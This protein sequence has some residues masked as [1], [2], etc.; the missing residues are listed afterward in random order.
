[1]AYTA[2]SVVYGEQPTAA[3]WNQLGQND[4]GFRDGTNIDDDTILERH[5]ADGEVTFAK[6]DGIWWEELGRTTLGSG[7]DT[8]SVASFTARKYLRIL[9]HTF[10]SN[11]RGALRFNNDSGNNYAYRV[12]DS[13]GADSTGT[14]FNYFVVGDAGSNST[15]AFST[16]D[17]INVASIEKI[18]VGQTVAKTAAGAGTAPISRKTFATWGNTASQITRVDAINTST[19]DFS[20]GSELVVLGH[21]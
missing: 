20:A 8:I 17:L 9:L 14:S 11:T 18:G 6:T 19:G 10:G 21:D 5:I 15:S 3:K 4:A 1:M 13:G 16:V 12:S 7:S 2:W